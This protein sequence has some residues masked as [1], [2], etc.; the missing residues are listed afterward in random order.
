MSDRRSVN[1]DTYTDPVVEEGQVGFKADTQTLK[2]LSSSAKAAQAKRMQKP[3]AAL[4]AAVRDKL[5][6]DK[7]DSKH[8]GAGK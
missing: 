4:D 3:A 1:S 8:E 5:L 2:Q 6:G 7:S